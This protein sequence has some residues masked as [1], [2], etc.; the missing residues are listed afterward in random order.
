VVSVGPT[1]L[2]PRPLAH[3]IV[4]ADRVRRAAGPLARRQRTALAASGLLW[5]AEGLVGVSGRRRARGRA[6]RS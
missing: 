3:L 1:R 5:L 2:L 6:V 4:R